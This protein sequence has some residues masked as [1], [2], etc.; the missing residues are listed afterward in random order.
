MSMQ[1]QLKRGADQGASAARENLRKGEAK[2]QQTFEAA[3]EGFQIAGDSARQMTLKLVEIARANTEA[4]WSFAEDI[5]NARDATK[6]AEIWTKHTQNQM[7]LFGRQSQE[8][9]SLGQKMT[10]T[11]INTMSDRAR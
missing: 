2:A 11:G 1:E 4:F 9:A 6:L 10:S 7:E 8:L 3:Q 5:L